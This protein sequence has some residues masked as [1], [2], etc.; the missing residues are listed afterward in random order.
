MYEY[1]QERVIKNTQKTPSGAG[2]CAEQRWQICVWLLLFRLTWWLLTT[3]G[4][5]TW[6]VCVFFH[7]SFAFRVFFSILD[8]QW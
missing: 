2:L 5:E 7:Y 1:P 6:P 4:G 3:K 8:G